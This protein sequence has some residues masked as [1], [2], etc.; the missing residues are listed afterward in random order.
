MKDQ[1]KLTFDYSIVDEASQ[2][3]EPVILGP[4]LLSKKFILVGDYMQVINFKRK[5]N[6]ILLVATNN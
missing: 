6:T 4:I 5:C 2:S 3:V 1:L